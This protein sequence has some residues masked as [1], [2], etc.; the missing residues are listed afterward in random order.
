MGAITFVISLIFV[1]PFVLANLDN[2]HK[3]F[4]TEHNNEIDLEK[5]RETAGALRENPEISKVYAKDGIQND[6]YNLMMKNK[7]RIEDHNV[8]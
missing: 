6:E 2:K 7:R 5:Y 3:P 1:V 4:Q 8:Q